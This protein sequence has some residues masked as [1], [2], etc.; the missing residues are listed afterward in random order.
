MHVRLP[1]AACSCALQFEMAVAGMDVQMRLAEA[2]DTKEGFKELR[3]LFDRIDKDGDGTVT[4]KEWGKAVSANMD[5]M[6]KYFGG[7]NKKA[8]GKAFKRIDADGSGESCHAT[9]AVLVHCTRVTPCSGRWIVKF[10][11]MP[12][13][14]P[15][16]MPRLISSPDAPSDARSDARS[17]APWPRLLGRWAHVGRVC[18]GQPEDDR[19]VSMNRPPAVKLTRLSLLCPRRRIPPLQLSNS[20]RSAFRVGS[21]VPITARCVSE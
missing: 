17:D 6:K 7:K 1:P 16:L 18:G 11:A 21:I 3:E 15:R 10:C 2:L 19:G 13:L 5:V 8:I 4:G 20:P 9:M 12:S 14:V